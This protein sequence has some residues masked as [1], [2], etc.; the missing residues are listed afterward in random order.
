MILV[1]IQKIQNFFE[2]TNEKDIGKI[3]Y[4]F[5]GVIVDRFIGLKSKMYSIKKIVGKECNIA[6]GVNISTE[7]NEFKNVLF[8]K[9]IIRHKMRRIQSKKHKLGTYEIEKIFLSCFDDKRY[10]LDDE[11][12]TLAY[13]HKDGVTSCKKIQ[14]DCNKKEEIKKDCDNGKRL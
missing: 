5:G 3:K 14:K 10:V 6:K 7:F 9:K 12:H 11:I 1:T 4:E 8:N 2:E 13:F